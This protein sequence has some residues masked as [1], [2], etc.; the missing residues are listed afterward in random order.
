MPDQTPIVPTPAIAA[1]HARLDLFLGILERFGLVA[2]QLAPVVVAPLVSPQT[3]AII[4]AETPAT[5]A[6]AQGLAALLKPQ[7]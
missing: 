4:A 6:L 2:L 3:A 7:A 5:N 1:H